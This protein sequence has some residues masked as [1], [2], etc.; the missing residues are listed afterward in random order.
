MKSPFFTIITPSYN[1]GKY[2]DHAIKSVLSQSYDNY[3]FWVIDGASTDDT[4]K[5]LKKYSSIDQYQDKFH[6]ISEADQ[7][8]TNAINK[9]LRMAKGEWFAWLNADDYYEPGAF[10]HLTKIAWDNP[11]AG[12]IYGNCRTHGKV[13]TNNIP[14]SKIDFKSLLSGNTIYGPAAFFRRA[15]IEA[16]GEFDEDLDL[17]M[18]FDMFMRIAKKYPLVYTNKLLAHF[19]ERNQQKSKKDIFKLKEESEYVIQKGKYPLLKYYY[20]WRYNI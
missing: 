3:E 4:I 15:A 5:I 9:G 16:V 2:L 8:Q 19:T 7:G 1:L 14:P 18:D 17:W 12:V 20:K 6:W 13:I 10:Q 11:S